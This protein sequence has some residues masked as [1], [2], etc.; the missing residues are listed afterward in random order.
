MLDAGERQ[1]V[2]RGGTTRRGGA[3][4]RVHGADRGAGGAGPDAVAVVCGD[5]ELTYGELEAR[6]TAGAVPAA[7]GVGPE[8]VV[9]LCLARGVGDGGGGAGGVEGGGAYLPLDPGYP[10]ERLAF[11][12]ADSGA[13]VVVGRGARPAELRR[14][15]AGVGWMTRRWLAGWPAGML[16]G[17]RGRGGARGSWRT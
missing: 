4:G 1:Q 6:A 13:G 2:L 12:L 15:R 9:G 8:T 17:G 10:A 16:A 11:M 14:G 7:A 3:G 5:A